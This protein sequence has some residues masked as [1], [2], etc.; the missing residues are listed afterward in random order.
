[1]GS[2]PQRQ[3]VLTFAALISFVLAYQ[4]VHALSLLKT[5]VSPEV[6]LTRIAISLAG[7]FLPILGGWFSYRLLGSVFFLLFG[8]VMVFF[9]GTVSASPIFVWFLFEYGA[10]CLLL[11]RMDQYFEN[12]HAAILLDRELAQNEKNDLEVSYKAKGEGISILFEKY[13]TYY[14]LRKLAEDLAT[15]LST[16]AL[17]QLVV[18]R[19]VDFIP[20]AD[21]A[22]LMLAK[23]DDHYLHEI[24][25]H[26]SVQA[27]KIKE[28]QS[29][30]EKAGNR[31]DQWVIKNRRRLI[32]TDAHQDFRFDLKET[33][34]NDSVRSVI[35]ASLVQEG[36]V[37]G[38]LRMNSSKPL[39]FTND[40]LRLLDTIAV[41][42]SSA[43]SNSLLYEKTVELAIKDSLTGLYVRRYFF[44]RLQEEI[45]RS[46]MTQK[47][48][49]V[50]MCDVDHFKE[51]ND[52]Y[53]HAVGDLV[54]VHVADILKRF[55]SNA[56]VGRYGGEEF[57]VLLV[58]TPKKEAEDVAN[59]VREKLENN[60]VIVRREEIKITMSIGVAS[61]PD[62][63][64]EGSELIGLADKA[65]YQAKK[66]GR[67]RVCLSD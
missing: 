21:K 49:S 54:L 66:A 53:G 27:Q 26:Y 10:L 32:V 39:Y 44:E 5:T 43:L 37:M 30:N 28:L 62:D 6:Q 23:D 51:C 25:S 58:E 20:K 67:N 59:R 55:D 2:G 8:S 24:A 61:L 41:L 1:M 14:N 22:V 42:T 38:T 15:T 18:D 33:A 48:L 57:C 40:D 47:S 17:A 11:Y 34:Q 35:A 12:Q 36:R 16:E 60:P 50:L 9:A 64:V 4:I 56:I 45:K 52:K 31:Y 63:S 46:V 65:L 29:I 3:I 13:A 19:C 7:F